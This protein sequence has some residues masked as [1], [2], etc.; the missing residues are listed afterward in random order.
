MQKIFLLL[1]MIGSGVWQVNAQSW[2]ELIEQGET[3]YQKIKAAGELDYSEES[4]REKGTGY[5]QFKRWEWLAEQQ[6][7]DNGK[8]LSARQVYNEWQVFEAAYQNKTSNFSG[9]WEPHGPESWSVMNNGYSPGNGRV[10]TIVFDSAHN[11]TM[12]VGTPSGGLWR[13]YNFGVTYECLTDHLPILGVSNVCINPHDSNIIYLGTGDAYA[14]DNYTI[15]VLKTT[16]N[17]QTWQSTGLSWP[18]QQMVRLYRLYL[19]PVDTNILIATTS[20]GVYRTDDGGTTWSQRSSALM[21]SLIA[22]P[23]NP[24]ILYGARSAIFKSTDKGLTWSFSNNGI[25]P[26][27]QVRRIELGMSKADTSVIYA[28]LAEQNTNALL[29]VYKSIQSRD[30]FALVCDTPN[31]LHGS[32]DGSGSTG[33]GWYDLAI[34]VDPNNVNIVYTGGVNIWK[35][36]DG[37]NSFQI[38]S[39]WVYSNPNVPYVHADIHYLGFWFNRLYSGNDGGVHFTANGGN[40][41][42]DQSMGLGITQI[43]RL[44]TSATNPDIIHF[45]AQDNGSMRYIPNQGWH[46][47]FGADGMECVIDYTNPNIGVLSSQNGGLRIS[48]DGF[49]SLTTFMQGVNEPSGWVTPFIIH[50]SNPLEYTVGRRTLWRTQNRGQ[51][52]TALTPTDNQFINAIAQ[53]KYDPATMYYSRSNRMWRTDDNGLTWIQ[54]N[55]G[56]PNRPITSIAIDPYDGFKVFV[57]YSGYGAGQKVYYSE[58]GGAIWENISYNL[59]NISANCLLIQESSPDYALYLGT[60][61]GVYYIDSTLTDWEPYNEGLPNVRV[62]ELEINYTSGDLVAATYGRGI[63]KSDLKWFN[64]NLDKHPT[65]QLSS[66]AYPNPFV[67]TVHINMPEN[68]SVEVFDLSGRLIFTQQVHEGKNTLNLSNLKSG[69]YLYATYNLQGNANGNGKLLKN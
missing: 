21:Q 7:D 20:Q 62:S 11:N 50:P 8:I 16:D 51:T 61:I 63:W 28:L 34:A 5:K 65:Q 22:N 2:M 55:F 59:P 64:L 43:Y 9:N 66:R 10:N 52:W 3:D 58:D 13:S 25:P 48:Q 1:I 46:Q 47:A 18:F 39:H 38:N 40:T 15:G 30:S 26:T 24:D 60:E 6:L 69:V 49:N 45:G 33:Q 36:V 27:G 42:V 31:I 19:H 17:G 12:Y 44:S 4:L 32:E 68:G 37:A 56:L 35:S 23:K 67:E 53:C 29:G 54:V 14:T 41:W 57:T